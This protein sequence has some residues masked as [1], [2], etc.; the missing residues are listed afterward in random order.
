MMAIPGNLQYMLLRKHKPCEKEIEG[1]AV[2][3]AKSFK[4]L[5]L[6]INHNLTFNT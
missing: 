3:S 4:L 5:G 2:E 1:S 6:T